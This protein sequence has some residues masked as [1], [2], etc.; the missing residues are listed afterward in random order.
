[1]DATELSQSS[2]P[3][4]PI[5]SELYFELECYQNTGPGFNQGCG[6][7]GKMSDSNSGLS[8]ISSSRLR[9]LNIKGMKFSC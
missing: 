3:A 5:A 8:K 9:L 4:I 6:V 1:M 2:A 7:G